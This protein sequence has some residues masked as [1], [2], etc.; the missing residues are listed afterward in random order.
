MSDVIFIAAIAL[1][2][3]IAV[4]LAA[5]GEIFTERSGVLNLGVEGMML[6]GAM[7][8][9]IIGYTTGSP[10]LA[11]S[12]AMAAGALLALIHAVLCVHLQAN[13]VISGLAVTILGTGLSSF[14]GRPFIGRVGIRIETLSSDWIS[15]V[16]LLGPILSHQTAIAIMALVLAPLA[17][18]VLMHTSFGLNI[19]A[20]GEDP[21]ATDAAGVSVTAYRYG[22]TVFGGMMAGLAGAYL[23]L[24]YTPGWKENMAGGQGW[25]AI[26]MVIFSSWKPVRALLGALIFG[27]LNALQF[28]FQATGL[29]L[30]PAYILRLLPYL[31]TLFILFTATA[32]G[33][34]TAGATPASLGKPFYRED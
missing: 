6:I 34:K 28:Y 1:K 4:L 27:G 29:E 31:M 23:S 8:G 24:V 17:G 2:S 30:I 22:C 7:T 33:K 14:I 10:L 11:F 3:S 16:P 12:G 19:R 13:Q 32:M 18:Y 26:A 9:F 25:I 5:I 21:K 15:A 20:S